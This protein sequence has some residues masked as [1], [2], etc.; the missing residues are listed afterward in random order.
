M[1]SRLDDVIDA[2]VNFPRGTGTIE[3]IEHGLPRTKSPAQL[4]A[5]GRRAQIFVDVVWVGITEEEYG[6]IWELTVQWVQLHTDLLISSNHI[7]IPR[8]ED[9]T[10]GYGGAAWI[11]PDDIDVSILTPKSQCVA[12]FWLEDKSLPSI[13]HGGLATA[14]RPLLGGKPYFSRPIAPFNREWNLMATAHEFIHVLSFMIYDTR[15]KESYEAALTAFPIDDP[16]RFK[17]PSEVT[18]TIL[19][20]EYAQLLEVQLGEKEYKALADYRPKTEFYY[21]NVGRTHADDRPEWMPEWIHPDIVDPI[22]SFKRIFSANP[23]GQGKALRKDIDWFL[24]V[25]GP[26][27]WD[28]MEYHTTCAGIVDGDTFDTAI[29]KSSGVADRIRLLGINTPE[30][31][32]PY[33]KEATEFLSNLILDKAVVLKTETLP[34]RDR[35]GRLLRWVYLEDGTFVNGAIINAGMARLD[36][37][38]DFTIHGWEIT[39]GSPVPEFV[40]KGVMLDFICERFIMKDALTV[41]YDFMSEIEVR[42]LLAQDVP[43]DKTISYLRKEDAIKILLSYGPINYILAAL[44]KETVFMLSQRFPKK[45][46]IAIMSQ[47]HEAGYLKDVTLPFVRIT[48]NSWFITDGLTA[49]DFIMLVPDEYVE[50][51]P[52]PDKDKVLS[53]LLDVIR[54]RKLN[55]YNLIKL[56]SLKNIPITLPRASKEDVIAFLSKHLREKDWD[57]RTFIEHLANLHPEIFKVVISERIALEYLRIYYPPDVLKL[58]YGKPSEEV[59]EFLCTFCV[60]PDDPRL[61]LYPSPEISEGRQFFAREQLTIGETLRQHSAEQRA[62]GA[63]EHYVPTHP[64]K[65]SED[66]RTIAN[67][68][69]LASKMFDTAYRYDSFVDQ[70]IA[71]GGSL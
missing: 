52:M 2:N 50:A 40:K 45:A 66:I 25:F 59:V 70:T 62:R 22:G 61:Q 14:G 29:C 35:Y 69:W 37:R 39:K 6:F 5:M 20:E 46:L 18:G 15:Y 28:S 36:I 17:Q 53:L 16:S 31:G 19:L 67:Y 60:D 42:A 4:E 10:A 1:T 12:I 38:Q 68:I 26:T 32:M 64:Y 55:T 65:P 8:P 9:T 21:A 49:S 47:L 41:L 33:Y 11:G 24:S 34:N 44:N 3:V 48:L 27:P 51:L 71:M 7:E 58:L 23:L 54:S 57:F 13:E 56:M 43:L 63:K 30:R